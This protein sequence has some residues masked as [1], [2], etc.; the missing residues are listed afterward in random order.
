MRYH[1]FHLRGYTVSDFGS[2]IVLH[3]VYDYPGQPKE[4]SDI[5]F[6]DVICHYFIHGS[7]AIIIRID[8][9]PIAE[10][11]R[12]EE[13]LLSSL[14]TKHGLNY[15]HTDASEYVRTLERKGF[16]VWR[17]ASATGF[18]GFVMARNVRQRESKL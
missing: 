1:E 6:S 5:E 15:W 14:A 16:R 4:R 18:G 12:E 9:E 8:E 17:I 13:Q 10:F 7:S 3:L 2:T 11:I